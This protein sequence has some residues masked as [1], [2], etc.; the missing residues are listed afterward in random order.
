LI[1]AVPSL[2][3]RR[4]ATQGSDEFS[5]GRSQRL[6]LTGVPPGLDEL[7]RL[8]VRYAQAVMHLR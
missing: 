4:Y 5:H 8:Q 3:L 1:E 7:A 6:G 2:G